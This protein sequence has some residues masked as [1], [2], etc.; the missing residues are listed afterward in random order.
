VT[1]QRTQN[2]RRRRSTAIGV[3]VVAV[4]VG[5]VAF[6]VTAQ[7]GLPAYLPGVDRGIVKA[8][9]SDAGAL[10]VGDDVRIADVRSGYVSDLEL[11]D[12]TPVATLQ[13][14]E[15][16]PVYRDASAA[17][18]ARSALGQKYVALNPGTP[19]AGELGDTTITTT[20]PSQE[21][22]T[23]LDVLD[24]PTREAAA[25]TVRE[26]GGGL[27]GRGSELR[28]GLTALPA[29]LPDLGT[30]SAALSAD[31]GAGLSDLL[32]AADRLS[33]SFAD[34]QQSIGATVR[35]LDPTL[36]AVNTDG[37]AR[38]AEVLDAAPDTMRQA[39]AALDALNG[40]LA[41]TRQAVTTV[42]PGA[43]A[44]GEATPDL[45]GVL[46]EAV[47][48]LDKVPGVAD[49]ADPAI[50]D[51]TPTVTDLRPLVRQLGTTMDQGAPSVQYIGRYSGD[52]SNF[53]TYFAD[54][55]SDSDQIGHGIRIYPMV[56]P[57]AV[58]NNLPVEDPTVH[59]D[60]YPVPGGTAD[61]HAESVIGERR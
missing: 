8:A 53:F 12:G 36:A 38:A 16:R 30:V 28:D 52:L 13:L 9:F 43:T 5:I 45:R 48:P 37:G 14:D 19:G 44:L 27:A 60:A 35:Q 47:G 46:R 25:S 2:R 41:A 20:T 21:L 4:L 11:V 23:L 22:D 49:S 7:N 39:R 6:A 29:V 31:G 40:P 34:R 50:T 32:T 51:L 24:E 58:L 61:H 54:T 3:A 10:R 57:E 42:R 59:R 18:G 26:V 17:V 55:L 1:S 15:G 33:R 56:K